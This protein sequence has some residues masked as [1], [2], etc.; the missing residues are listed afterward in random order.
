MPMLAVNAKVSQV[1][2]SSGRNRREA[3]RVKQSLAKTQVQEQ[4]QQCAV[5]GGGCIWDRNC[6]RYLLER[7]IGYVYLH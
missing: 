3:K 5:Q 4:E 1:M 7:P 6:C 2:H